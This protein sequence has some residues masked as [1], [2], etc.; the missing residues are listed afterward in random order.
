ML[1]TRKKK[2]LATV[3]MS[4]IVSTGITATEFSFPF[5]NFP[6]IHLPNICTRKDA[7]KVLAAIALGLTTAR[8]LMKK[9]T[10][11]PLLQRD[12]SWQ[13]FGRYWVD[14]ALIG[15]PGKKQEID[16]IDPTTGKVVYKKYC[17]RGLM[18][19]LV[20]NWG[21]KLLPLLTL[22]LILKAQIILANE[23]LASWDHATR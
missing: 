10:Q 21:K 1:L 3:T 23:G 7:I 6:S 15:Q 12:D 18:G 8:L 5:L 22:P 20:G 2:L 13:E 16:Y 17:P 14:E 4:L 11:D 9:Q 19:N